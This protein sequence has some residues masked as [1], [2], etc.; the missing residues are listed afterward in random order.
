MRPL[1]SAGEASAL[2]AQPET[3]DLVATNRLGN[4]TL[5]TKRKKGGAKPGPWFVLFVRATLPFF[6][7]KLG[8]S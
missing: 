6:G 4:S 3:A 8:I 5:R 2:R 1:R 7:G